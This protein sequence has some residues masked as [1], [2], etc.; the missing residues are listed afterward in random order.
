VETQNT[1]ATYLSGGAGVISLA[2]KSGGDQFHGDAFGV[3]RPN[4][5]AANEWFNKQAG[6]PT[7]AYHRYQEGGAIGGPILHKK[8]FFFGDYEATQQQAFD[9][10]GQFT[11]PTTAERTGDFS[12]DSFA[13]YDPTL[14]DNP[15]GTRQQVGS[16]GGTLNKIANPNPIAVKFLSEFPKCNYPVASTC[17]QATNGGVGQFNLYVPGLDPT[18]QQK[19]DVRIDYASEKQRIFGRFSFDRLFTSGVNAFNNPW[20]LDYAQN[21][22]NGR[23]FIIGDDYTI[24]PTTVLQLRY[25]FT[26]H[27]ENQGGDPGQNAIDSLSTLGFVTPTAADEVYKTLPYVNF[28]DLGGGIGGTAN[29]NTFIYASE[30]HDAIA[31]L[32]KS[33][34]KH[35]IS[36]GAEYMKRFL[37]DG[38]PPAPSGAYAFD[39]SATVE[40][41]NPNNPYLGVGGSDFASFLFG[42]GEESGA[43][44]TE[45]NDAP[46]FTK[47]LFVA[48]SNPYYAAFVEDTY[49]PNQALTI[50]AGVRWDIFDGKTERHNR[51]EYFDPT[52]TYTA[53]GYAGTLTGGE[54]FTKNG[55]RTPFTTNMHDI[56]PRL[57][58]SWQP[59]KRVVVRGGA[60]F[61]YGPSAHMVGSPNL[62]SDGF[63]SQTI[64][65]ATCLNADGNTVY[66]GT[67]GC[68]DATTGPAPSATGIYSLTNPFPTVGGVP[69]IIQLTGA[70]QGLETNLGSTLSTMMH[71][72]PTQRVYNFNF[73]VEYEFPREVVLSVGYVG[74]RG[75]YLPFA[76]VDLNQ[77]PLSTLA[78]MAIAGDSTAQIVAAEPFP[79]F[80]DGS[81]SATGANNGVIAHGY[82]AGDSEYSSLQTKVQK[83]LTHHFTTLASFTWGKI[84]TDDGNPPLTFVGAHAGSVQDWRNLNLEH[85]VSPQD[86][87]YQFTAQ[88][89]YDLPVG[90]GRAVNLH[91]VANA[92][93]GDWTTDAIFYLSTG[94]PI[95][96]PTVGSNSPYYF[97]QRTNMTC[98]PSK[99]A[100]HTAAQWFTPACFSQPTPGN[101]NVN[102]LLPY[103]A[104]NAPA[105]L[106]HVRT[107]G[108]DDFDFTLSKSF[109]LGGER[110]IRIDLTSYNVTNKA[111]LG[112]PTVAPEYGLV[113]AATDPN[114]PSATDLPSV[115]YS[116]LSTPFGAITSTVNSPRQFQGGARFTF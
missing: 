2:S 29:Y 67:I 83:R 15:D 63:S 114:C 24:S 57:G 81:I 20:D 33:W 19:F 105:Y 28:D 55:S 71:S 58:I 23:N 5:L 112:A 25:S 107:M 37:N 100:P 79:Q 73:G 92:I 95:N 38:Q 65:A 52:A 54:V 93:L 85:S 42:M 1:P 26:R 18:T 13:I 97:N 106:D 35:E 40:S 61:Y 12:A 69:G 51:L 108:A 3:F 22:T 91:G 53:A 113:C 70:T 31:T 9:G 68:A 11:V 110:N 50:T 39:N 21:I 49:H 75:L 46:N 111:Q 104:G 66:N 116:S 43:N 62:N 94:V 109:K 96:S 64:W 86:V 98:D 72:Q 47:D 16:N 80:T 59:E 78:S 45:G 32:T 30:N 34:G 6:N 89:S 77:L 48:E 4:V 84:M 99:G 17:D 60:G 115:P 82:P 56:G 101:P 14:P 74:S 27:Y 10:S 103:V 44:H 102:S 41:T 76:T 8:L 90:K 87:K 88:A 36:F 7:P